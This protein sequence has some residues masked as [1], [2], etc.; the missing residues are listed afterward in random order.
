MMRGIDN[1]SFFWVDVDNVS[2]AVNKKRNWSRGMAIG[3][4]LTKKREG[5]T[6]AETCAFFAL[7]IYFCLKTLISF[8]F[9]LIKKNLIT[10]VFSV[11][12]KSILC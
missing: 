4:V 8:G 3:Y 11:N 5:T 10:P 7:M 9:R 1:V 12:T 2:C 6:L